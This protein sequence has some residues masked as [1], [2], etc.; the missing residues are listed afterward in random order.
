MSIQGFLKK[1]N[2]DTLWD[3][4][5]DEDIFKFLSRDIQGKVFQVF[6]DNIKGFFE[7]EKTNTTE[8]IDMNKKYI[9]LILSHIRKNYPE[10][11]PNKIKIFDEPLVKESITY[12]EIQNEKK[13]QFEKD[14][15]KRQEEFTNAMALPVP[16]VPDFTDKFT[17]TPLTGMD[18][19][20]KEITA[21]RNYDIEQINRKNQE[22]IE[23]ADNWLKPQETS[24][25]SEKLITKTNEHQQPNNQNRLKY[26]NNQDKNQDKTLDNNTN[27]EK[28][29]NV[30]WGLNEEFYLHTSLEKIEEDE[31]YE[32]NIFKKLKKVPSSLENITLTMNDDSPNVEERLTHIEKT[33]EKY[34]NKMDK[35][36]ELLQNRENK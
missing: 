30:S 26:L 33:L 18:K 13:T 4:I 36:L 20:I 10:K 22:K 24:V 23:N 28:N 16:E 35:I 3:V 6:L 8:L 25:K 15:M 34:N 17:D 11:M 7:V 19:I 2:I 12:E 5:I 31:E 21:K 9:L 29:K 32:N 1:E 27:I 14:F